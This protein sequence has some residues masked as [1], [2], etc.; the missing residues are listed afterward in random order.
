MRFTPGAT[1]YISGSSALARLTPE[2]RNIA[3]NSYIEYAP[4][5]FKW[6]STAHSTR[7]GH[8]I[9]TEGL[10]MSWEDLEK[11]TGA[12]IEDAKRKS[13][14]MVWTNPKTGELCV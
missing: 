10:E 11:S 12:K 14:P 13:Y 8:S 4:H 3:M 5:C 1:A 7:L 9:E 6:M 2:Q